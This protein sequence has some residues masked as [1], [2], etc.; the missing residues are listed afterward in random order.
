MPNRS[1]LR[2]TGTAPELLALVVAVP[3]RSQ[4]H[5]AAAFGAGVFIDL[6]L[7]FFNDR[8]NVLHMINVR[9]DRWLQPTGCNLVADSQNLT[10]T[11]D[12][13]CF[14]FDEPEITA[15][16]DHIVRHGRLELAVADENDQRKQLVRIKRQRRLQRLGMFVILV[17]RILELARVP[18]NLLGP[19]L[20]LG[21]TEDPAFHIFG[22]YDEYAIARDNDMINLRR[23]ILGRQGNV[24]KQRIDFFI[25]KKLGHQINHELAQNAF[26]EGRFQEGDQKEQKN[27]PPI[28]AE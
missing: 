7:L 18:V 10:V 22:F 19:S 5:G 26:H 14:A 12:W 20:L 2:E 15:Q 16:I 3:G 24:F 11:E 13:L 9:S 25:E 4:Y 6:S 17:Q 1:A 21:I 28:G 27:Q 23:A 8:L